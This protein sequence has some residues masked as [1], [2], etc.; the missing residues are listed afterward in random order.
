MQKVLVFLIAF[1]VTPSFSGCLEAEDNRVIIEEPTPFDFSAPIPITTF[2]HYANSVSALNSTFTD[3]EYPNMPMYAHGTYYS[4]DV[5]TFEPT[6][7]VTTSGALFMTA[8][9]QGQGGAT[10]IIKCTGIREMA[11]SSEYLCEDVGPSTVPTSNDPYLY[12][13]LWTNRLMKF[14]MHALAGMTVEYSDDEGATWQTSLPTS[15]GYTPQDHQTIAS[16]PNPPDW[17]GPLMYETVW[18]YCINT[19]AQGPIGSQCESS[20]DGGDTWNG[21]VLGHPASTQCAGLTGHLVGAND[22]YIYRGNPSCDGPAAYRSS[23]GGRT[24]TEHTINTQ[25]GTSTHEI[26]LATDEDSN[27]HAVWI[28]ED[29]LPYY[30][31]SVDNAN[32]WSEAMMVAPPGVTG[33]GFPTV[34]AGSAG[35]VAVGYIGQLGN[36][37]WNGYMSIMTD[38]FND[39][40]LITTV[41]VNTP[42][43]P[44][45]TTEDCGYRRCGGFGDF[46]DLVIDLDGRPWIALAN[47]PASSDDG[48][49][50]G[51][52]GTLA[53]GPSLRGDTLEY[54][55][56]IVPGGA[57]TLS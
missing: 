9:N 30:S 47:N 21:Q 10:A 13:D 48:D 37:S 17:F 6:I 4:T 40:P 31:Y 25:T 15:G 16:V 51:I 52:F 19:G 56:P 42:E 39:N 18:V 12:V 2:Y 45:D 55:E 57:S 23:D 14:D 54:L 41:A 43:D 27:I 50:I 34:A 29:K 24:W 38:S 32:T 5:P 8:W 36:S 3:F 49:G 28:G 33:T 11:N 22:G 35:R 44:L 46:I 26:A 20:F 7:G 1:L 53:E